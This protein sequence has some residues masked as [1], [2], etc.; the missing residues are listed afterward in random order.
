V[1]TWRKW[2]GGLLATGAVGATL[3]VPSLTQAL[4]DGMTQF[5]SKQIGLDPA[6]IQAVERGE[7]VVKDLPT[8]N[9]RDVA[10]FGVIALDV[11]RE[12]Y[13]KR[14][15][16]FAA[17]LR[18]PTQ[19][20]FGIFGNPATAADVKSLV[21]DQQSVSDLKGCMPNDCK[22]K[23][24]ATVMKQAQEDIDWSAPDLQARVSAY[25]RPLLV[26]HVNDYRSR[27]DAAM[28]VYD[29]RGSVKASDAFQALMAQSPYVYQEI[30]SLTQY[31]SRYPKGRLDGASE[32]I[33]WSVDAQKG[34]KQ[35]LSVTHAIVYTPPESPGLTLLAAK[36]IYVDHYFEAGFDL[37]AVTERPPSGV[38]VM[39]L[40]RWRF[41]DLRTGPV[42]NL[43]AKVVAKLRDQMR[44]DLQ[45]EK[46]IVERTAH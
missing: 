38:H 14:L 1:A 7:V 24:P 4:P 46:G 2:A 12:A 33:Y 40:R 18:T 43:R 39:R 25:V 10:I 9:S 20:Q 41:D 13:E 35:I 45:R 5:L 21:W 27:G 37:T 23:L 30:P 26:A 28:V 44:A 32:A 6:Q 22:I 16:N 34:L 19:V 11:S 36:Q 17:S 8:K 31:L 42:V 3:I 29:N 15:R